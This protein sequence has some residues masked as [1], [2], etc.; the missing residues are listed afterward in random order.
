MHE[1]ESLIMGIYVESDVEM[2]IDYEE[3][4]SLMDLVNH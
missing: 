1:F 3:K 4:F 2:F